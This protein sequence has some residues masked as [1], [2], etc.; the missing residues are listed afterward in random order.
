MWLEEPLP[1]PDYL[2][3][4]KNDDWHAKYAVLAA[5]TSIPLAAGENHVTLQECADAI[6]RGGISVMQFDA[7][8]HGGV[9]EFLRVAALC[10]AFGVDMSP[11][12]CAHFHAQL[13]A[14]I[15]NLGWV[16]CYDNSRQQPSWPGLFDGFPEVRDG[17]VQLEERPGWGMTIN[18]KVLK[19]HG[20][21]IRWNG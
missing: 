15:P 7:V 16:E 5:A 18:E 3:P 8:K 2:R 20:T 14:A 19:E 11:H 12:H 9:S 10:E 17:H 4:G 21:L 13:A 6:T 1:P